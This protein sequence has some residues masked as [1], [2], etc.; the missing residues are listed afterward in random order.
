M[1][2]QDLVDM[3]GAAFLS[4]QLPSPPFYLFRVVMCQELQD[5]MAQA[6]YGHTVDQ[7]AGVYLCVCVCACVISCLCGCCG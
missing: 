6:L 7:A 1:F 4:S 5:V 2:V 3:L